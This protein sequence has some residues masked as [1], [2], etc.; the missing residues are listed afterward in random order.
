[1]PATS[2]SSS[3]S[4]GRCASSTPIDKRS[5]FRRSARRCS[6]CIAGEA[7][8]ALVSG[9]RLADVRSRSGLHGSTWF[10]GLHGLEIAGPGG[11]FAHPGV[12]HAASLMHALSAAIA[13]DLASLPGT[14]VEDKGLSLAVHFRAASREDAVR[15][16]DAM[17][18]HAQPHVSAGTGP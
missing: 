16:A 7:T 4:T 1:M 11:D 12:T 13:A 3:T 5:T 10:A 18:R 15:A 9:R 17:L 14:F 6:D 2:S 8:V